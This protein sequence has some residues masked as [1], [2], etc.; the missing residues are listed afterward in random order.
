LIL[1]DKKARNYARYLGLSL[2][3]TL[4][5]LLAAHQA[6]MLEEIDTIISLQRVR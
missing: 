6:G 1:D 4:G 3:G 5:L 2:T